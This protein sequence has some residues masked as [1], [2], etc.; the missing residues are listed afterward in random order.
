MDCQGLLHS[1]KTI[2]IT[3]GWVELKTKTGMKRL[4]LA[5]GENVVV[6]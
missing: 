4:P 1:V 6:D 5:I 3:I 2:K